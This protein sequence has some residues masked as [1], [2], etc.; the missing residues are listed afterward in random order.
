LLALSLL[1]IALVAIAAELLPIDVVALS[2][3]LL[4]IVPAASVQASHHRFGT[5]M[6]V[7]LARSLSSMAS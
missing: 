2:A 1:L 3:V 5:D 6:V 7:L 4:L